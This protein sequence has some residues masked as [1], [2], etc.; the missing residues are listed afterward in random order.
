MKNKSN[1][2]SAPKLWM[3]LIL[4]IRL[5]GH[6]VYRIHMYIRIQHSSSIVRLIAN[7]IQIDFLRKKLKKNRK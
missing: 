4:I 7:I 3:H 1:I 6:K 5:K 2:L